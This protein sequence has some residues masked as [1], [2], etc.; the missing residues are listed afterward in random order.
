MTEVRLQWLGWL[1]QLSPY[2]AALWGPS[3]PSCRGKSSCP[4]GVG[5]G[6]WAWTG[7]GE[8]E[9]A[10]EALRGR[11]SR[12]LRP[13]PWGVGRVGTGVRGP[14]GSGESEL[15]SEALMIVLPIQL[16]LKRAQE[17]CSCRARPPLVH[18]RHYISDVFSCKIFWKIWI[19][20]IS[21]VF[22]KYCGSKD[23]SHQFQPNCVIS[24]YF[25]L[26]LILHAYV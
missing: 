18:A 4:G 16:N 23:S 26:Y 19:I 8:S 3:H 9:L 21:F 13:R 11:A 24:F 12:N 10:S 22:N 6:I 2:P 1:K 25:Y 5:S 7:S 20:Q 17:S 15:A 14:E